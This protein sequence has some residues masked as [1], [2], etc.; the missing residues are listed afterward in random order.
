MNVRAFLLTLALTA[1]ACVPVAA[2]EAQPLARDPALEQRMIALTSQLRCLVC[3]NES[4]AASQADL[5]LDLREQVREM[6]RRGMS[7]DQIVAYLVAR[8][9][10][11]VRYKPPFD[12]ETALLWTAPF[13]LVLLGLGGL[14]LLV[15]ARRAAPDVPPLDAE[16]RAKVR[17]LLDGAG[18][19]S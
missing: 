15:R 17:A 18:E 4:L 14:V 12:A 9:G 6:M 8:Y 7:D 10:N 19:R 3:Q 13:A 2:R 5:A 11:F 16:Q 1:A